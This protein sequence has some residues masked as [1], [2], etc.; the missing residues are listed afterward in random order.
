MS[1][2]A[3]TLL[4]PE[5]ADLER[6][7][8]DW[9]LDTEQA[10]NQ[11]RV[12]QPLAALDDFYHAIFPRMDALCE[13]IDRYSI[14]GLPRPAARLLQLGLM[15]M[16]VVPAVEIYRAPDVPNAFEFQRFKIISPAD[17]FTIIDP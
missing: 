2:A 10:R 9:V 7:A 6:Y 14:D 16:E 13:Y 5:F 4:P 17:P 11:F 8:N 12:R 15:L 3:T 1:T